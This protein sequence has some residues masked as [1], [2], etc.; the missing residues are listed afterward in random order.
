MSLTLFPAWRMV[1]GTGRCCRNLEED[2]VSITFG[3][4]FGM[5]SHQGHCPE[6]FDALNGNRL[7]GSQG[8]HPLHSVTPGEL[9]R[10]SSGH[11]T[12]EIVIEG[13]VVVGEGITGRIRLQAVE[14]VS[15]R[16]GGLRLVGL[17][18]VEEQRSVTHE[19]G[20]HTSS[21]EHWVEANG[22][23]FDE[24]PLLEPALP[25]SLAAGETF[26]ARFTVPAPRLGPPSAHL[27]EAIVAWAL[28]ARW[29]V[30]MSDAPFV[31]TLVPVAQNPEL[32][33]AGVGEQGGLS[34]LDTVAVGDA[35]ISVTSPLPAAPGSLVGVQVLWA[36]APDG[37]A[38]IELHRRTN[39]PNGVEGIIASAVTEA[40]A[41]RSGAA[42]VQ[43]ALPIDSA[44]SFD[45]AGLEITYVIR[46]L[47]DRRFRPD[48]AIERPVA[49]A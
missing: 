36:S 7:A 3:G 2:I 19:R 5:T 6:P 47:V 41:I 39:A 34:M 17:R 37:P 13:P 25:S 22:S 24:E 40:G 26:E 35:R 28:A 15:A 14:P 43:L 42:Q 45:G 33:R 9:L 20:D 18:L 32:I 4:G 31:A 11:V 44:P 10:P 16:K 49:V 21:T 12:G 23:L 1:N 29:D 48:T 46:V 8:S 38:R 30:P 27:G